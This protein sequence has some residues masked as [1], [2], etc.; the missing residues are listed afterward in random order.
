[1]SLPVDDDPAG[2]SV[3]VTDPTGNPVGEVNIGDDTQIQ[4]PVG[5]SLNVSS[6]IVGM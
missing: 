1:M 6:S 5:S 4:L 2:D 3:V